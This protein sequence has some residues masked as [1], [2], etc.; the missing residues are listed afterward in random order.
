MSLSLDTVAAEFARRK[1]FATRIVAVLG[2][3]SYRE[4]GKIEGA[5]V[6]TLRAAI[7]DGVTDNHDRGVKRKSPPRDELLKSVEKTMAPLTSKELA[8][9]LRE[10][11]ASL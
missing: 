7:R 4:L 10:F 2:P 6:V 5:N 11:A 1:A 3:M 9:R 8:R